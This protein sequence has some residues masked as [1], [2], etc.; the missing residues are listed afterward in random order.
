M[1]A[2]RGARRRLSK[3]SLAA[4]SWRPACDRRSCSSSGQAHTASL[5]NFVQLRGA[6]CLIIGGRQSAYEWAALLCDHE[7]ERIDIVHRHD[8]PRFAAADWS[9]VDAYIHETL[10]TPGWWRSLPAAERE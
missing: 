3:T 5:V 1:Q 10:R 4:P 7:A 8:V 9:F 2:Q 6:R